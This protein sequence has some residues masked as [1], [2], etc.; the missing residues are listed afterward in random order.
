MAYK[1]FRDLFLSLFLNNE[2]LE[3]F[4]YDQFETQYTVELNNCRPDIVVSNE[5]YEILIEAKTSDSRLTENQPVTYLQHLYESGEKKKYLIFLV[6]SNYA[7]QHIWSSK[8]SEFTNKNAVTNIHIQIIYWNE[9]IHA[10]QKS[11][12]FLLSEK[13]KDFYDLLKMW[14]E[15]KRI[16]FTNSEVSCMFKTE[17]PSTLTKLYSIVNAVKGYSGKSFKSKPITSND[18]E[19]GVFFQ[20]KTGKDLLYFGVWYEFW[21]KHG[22][23]LC[24]GVFSEWNEQTVTR[25]ESRHEIT[26]EQ[27]DFIMTVVP[28]V[29]IRSEN[30]SEEIAQLIYNELV[31]LTNDVT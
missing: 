8:S 3:R 20:D 13:V 24:F 16:T 28:E 9:L 26:I 21:E 12:L 15:V 1:P 6:P 2:E 4:E 19:Y 17:V 23:P 27:E 29:M 10:I 25:F 5:E 7:Y 22:S 30:C 14:F 11:E 18:L 31:A